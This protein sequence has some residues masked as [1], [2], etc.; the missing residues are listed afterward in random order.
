VFHKINVT[1][2]LFRLHFADELSTNKMVRFIYQGRELQDPEILHT[3]NIRDQTTIHCQISTRRHSTP[4]RINDGIT[5]EY[6]NANGFDTSSFID[7]SPINI[8]SHFILFIT[9][10]LGSIWYLRIKYRI[11]FTPISTIILIL[12]TIIFLI[13]TCG[14]VLTTRR[15]ISDRRI[16]TQV[17]HAHL[18]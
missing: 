2:V 8:S 5:P 7:A 11:L 6:I 1:L 12:I 17:L 9:I 3:C 15:Q 18:D 4:N 16:P 10:I 14:S 13:F